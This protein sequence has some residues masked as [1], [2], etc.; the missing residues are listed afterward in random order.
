MG[1]IET[2]L[3]HPV[4]LAQDAG[5]TPV[6]VTLL[7]RDVVIWRDAAGGVHAWADQCPHRGARLSLGQVRG[8]ILECAYHGWTFD[9]AG[10]CTRVPAVPDFKPPPSHCATV[11]EA[12]EMYG[13]VWVRLA[14]PAPVTASRPQLPPTVMHPLPHAGQVPPAWEAAGNAHMRIVQCGPYAVATSA[15]RV[16]EIFL[17][18]AHFGFVHE[19]YLG[20]RDVTAIADY[21]VER[22]AHGIKATGCR[23]WQPQSHAQAQ[24][25]A[26][27]SY[28]YEV[29]SPYC[30]VLTKMPAAADQHATDDNHSTTDWHESIALWVCPVAPESSRVWF[31]L[32]VADA[33]SPEQM[34]QDFQTTIFM[35]DK[36]ILESQR[37]AL[38]P[39]DVRA[40]LHTVAD[41]ASSAYRRYLQECGITFGVC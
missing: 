28:T 21:T 3:W 39:L 6:A 17:D 32:A 22:T 27:V 24:Q 1:M 33:D 35:Q 10:L 19:G 20:A 25:G 26:Q 18:M 11:F 9:V 30:A 16:V 37:P 31:S 34:L 2:T 40:E 12:Q 36:P 15:P 23:A 29:L 7:A 5:S 14:R 38:L 8:D 4:A 41:K 13:M